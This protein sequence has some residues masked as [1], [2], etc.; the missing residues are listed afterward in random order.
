MN[1]LRKRIDA[2]AWS[3][4]EEKLHKDGAAVIPSLLN[5]PERQELINL[6]GQDLFRS[7]IVMSR[8][9]FG[10]GEYK[11]FSY[12]LPDMITAL[13]HAFYPRL[14]PIAN[15]WMRHMAIE[16]QYPSTLEEF[17]KQCHEAGQL[18]PTPLMLR[19]R[20]GDFNCLHQDLYGENMFPLQVVFLLNEPGTDFEGGELVLVEQR[21]RMQSKPIVLPLQAGD[22]AIFAV[23]T[24]P[25]NG[26]R[27]YY[28]VNMK[29]GVSEIRRGERHT[30]GIIFHDAL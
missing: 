23:G 13:R 16:R 9:N 6:Y 28:R 7:R 15:Q 17:T 2:L 18:R 27:G 5:L 21:P 11:Y 3:S 10:K 24:R 20:T 26:T 22:A 8:Y 19:Y 14:V 12:P 25:Q 29:H 4:I 1:D 30:L